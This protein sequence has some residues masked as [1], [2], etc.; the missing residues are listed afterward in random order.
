MLFTWLFI[1][2]EPE[3][4][5]TATGCSLQNVLEKVI[6]VKKVLTAIIVLIALISATFAWSWHS[7]ATKL[8]RY[9]SDVRPGMQVEVARSKARDLGLKC[10]SSSRQDGAGNYHD[11]VTSG[12][13]MGR[14]VVEV[15]HDGKTVTGVV[16][17]V[18]D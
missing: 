18:N 6:D 11:L 17:H 14:K 4:A 7:A 12:A 15:S 9:A 13:V 1:F 10:I 3:Y 8:S 5:D 2:Q 16:Q